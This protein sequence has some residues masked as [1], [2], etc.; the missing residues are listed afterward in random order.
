M[1]AANIRCRKAATTPSEFSATASSNTLPRVGRK[2]AATGAESPHKAHQ[3][4]PCLEDQKSLVE[5]R[6]ERR[7]RAAEGEMCGN[8]KVDQQRDQ[9]AD[10]SRNHNENPLTDCLLARVLRPVAGNGAEENPESSELK[11]R[12][13]RKQG[14]P[15]PG[16]NIG[17]P[18]QGDPGGP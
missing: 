11:E 4:T 5:I 18:A 10:C 15:V 13:K 3:E 14:A 17:Q 12:R 9:Q 2:P 6:R 7:G 16:I 1:A 8:P